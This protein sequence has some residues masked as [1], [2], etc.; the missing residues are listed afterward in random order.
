MRR[1]DI[2]MVQGTLRLEQTNAM[3]TDVWAWTSQP[4]IRQVRRV[5]KRAR[6]SRG[7][8]ACGTAR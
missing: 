8:A 3:W 7:F 5:P 4:K 2:H 6:H 1:Y